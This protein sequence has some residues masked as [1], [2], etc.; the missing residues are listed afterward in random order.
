MDLRRA[1]EQ[2]GF[3]FVHG[4]FERSEIAA[5]EGAVMALARKLLPGH[6]ASAADLAKSDPVDVLG[7]IE[8]DHAK[9]FY[10][11]CRDAGGSLAGLHLA[12]HDRCAEVMRT[13]VGDRADLLFPTVPHLFYNAKTVTRLHADWHQES[14]YYPGIEGGLHS[15]FPMFR[16]IESDDGPMLVAKGSHL[17]RYPFDIQRTDNGLTQMRPRVD[18][19]STFEIVECNLALGDVVFFHHDLIHATGPNRSGR[20][21][22]S[23]F[24]RYM[25]MMASPQFH[26]VLGFNFPLPPRPD[27][28]G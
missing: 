19:E 24:V 3:V 27:Q 16:N 17:S 9:E 23:G 25:D 14:A 6:F 26:S 5:Y 13:L 10:A 18:V 7:S 20:P 4:L 2:D 15:W 21:R 22:V 28:G 8:R 12:A 11:V 1:F